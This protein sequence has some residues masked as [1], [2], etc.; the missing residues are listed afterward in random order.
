MDR[1][2]ISETGTAILFV[3]ASLIGL[4]LALEL[5]SISPTNPSQNTT[6]G[7][8]YVIYFIIAVVLMSILI[9]VISKKKKMGILRIIFVLSMVFVIFIVSSLLYALLPITNDEYYVLIFGTPILFLYLLLFKQNWIILNIAG[10]LTSAGLAAVWGIDLGVYSAIALMIIFAVYDYIAVYK[11]KHMLD[12]ARASTDSNMPLFFVVPEKRGFDMNDVDIDKPS[13]GE[14]G[15]RRGAIMIG[16]GDIAIPNVMVISSFLYGNT[17]QFFVL[18]LFGGIVAMFI[19]FS[20]IKRPAP[21]LPFLNTGV[22]LGF[23]IAVL[24]RFVF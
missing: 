14:E 18:P 16:F 17:I 20:F 9:I 15:E 1:R 22:L 10:V 4:V 12:I 5:E 19:L 3:I 6:A 13:E 21:G 11:T 23:A 7:L 2:I 8:G 24:L